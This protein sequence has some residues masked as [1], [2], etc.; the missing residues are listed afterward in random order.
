[1]HNKDNAV[2]S[3]SAVPAASALPTAAEILQDESKAMSQAEKTLSQER[4]SEA[5]K[6]QD[7]KGPNAQPGASPQYVQQVVS[8]GISAAMDALSKATDERFCQLEQ[9]VSLPRADQDHLHHRFCA[10]ETNVTAIQNDMRQLLHQVTGLPFYCIAAYFGPWWPCSSLRGC[11]DATECWWPFLYPYNT[12]AAEFRPDKHTGHKGLS[13]VGN[14]DRIEAS[15]SSS[16]PHDMP[17]ACSR[18]D[19]PVGKYSEHQVVTAAVP[20][21]PDSFLTF[22]E[23]QKIAAASRMSLR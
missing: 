6:G 9:N 12:Q 14:S 23:L 18:H 2:P 22:S 8:A 10:L 5:P 15:C 13:D 19:F 11:Y 3:A 7:G 17:V 21:V 1:M 4:P 20:D 16:E